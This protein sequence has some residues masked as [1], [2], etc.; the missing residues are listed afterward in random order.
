MH[1]DCQEFYLKK[2]FSYEGPTVYVYPHFG[3]AT[4]R[5]IDYGQTY[6]VWWSA[7]CKQRFS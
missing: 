6:K 4:P 2:T 7:F 1:S 3:K 5:G